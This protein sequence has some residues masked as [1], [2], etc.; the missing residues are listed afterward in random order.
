MG[1]RVMHTNRL[2]A[3]SSVF[4][5]AIFISIS[6]STNVWALEAEDDEDAKQ[7]AT[8]KTED[9]AAEGSSNFSP[10][11]HEHVNSTPGLIQ[12]L[13]LHNTLCI[14]CG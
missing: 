5:F 2:T 14:T 8:S 10:P 12:N 11:H 4:V 3:D 9:A 1:T 13:T 7:D 6:I